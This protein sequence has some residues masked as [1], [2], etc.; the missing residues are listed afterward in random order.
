VQANNA[1]I[2]AAHD[3]I[4][5]FARRVGDERSLR[6]AACAANLVPALV[7]IARSFPADAALLCSVFEALTRL[8]FNHE[9]NKSA[10]GCAGAADLTV[11][12]LKQRQHQQSSFA[13]HCAAAE[14]L[15][16]L[17]VDHSQ[18]KCIAGQAAAVHVVL[19]ILSDGSVEV[20]LRCHALN[21]LERLMRNHH[22]NKSIAGDAHAA[23]VLSLIVQDNS[24]EMQLRCKSADAITCLVTNHSQNK[25][26][27]G[28]TTVMAVTNALQGA[29][30][31]SEL[32]SRAIDA[33]A[34]LVVYQPILQSAAAAAGALNCLLSIAFSSCELRSSA[35]D[36]IY[37]IVNCNFR[38]QQLLYAELQS[39]RE[40]HE[41]P[42]KLQK[43]ALD[44]DTIFCDGGLLQQLNDW[45]SSIVV[46]EHVQRRQRQCDFAFAAAEGALRDEEAKSEDGLSDVYAGDG[47]SEDNTPSVPQGLK[48]FG[49]TCYAF[50]CARSFNHR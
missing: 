13:L 18:N 8:M 23:R 43:R 44:L 47:V 38:N 39:R 36:A 30:S 37:C 50:A 48:Q 34:A 26:K 12:V 17:V 22:D 33:I 2:Q 24:I 21:A 3:F 25:L 42:P 15:A 29:P 4:A 11:N 27:A 10:A 7:T 35:D 20:K 9:G 49:G 1:D 46:S 5:F 14:A 28:E 16:C 40:T 6:D 32:Q 19:D 45:C 41:L 31:G